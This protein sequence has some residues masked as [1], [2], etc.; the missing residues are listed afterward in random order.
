MAAG[1]VAGLLAVAL[2]ADSAAAADP[3]EAVEPAS[4]R[5]SALH[6]TQHGGASV[7]TI[8]IPAVELDST[9]RS[10]IAAEVI[11]QGVAHWVGTASPGEEGNVVLAG[12]RTTHSRPFQDL[13]RLENGDLI[14]LTDG[15]GFESM[16]RVTDVFIV[17]PGDVWIT[18]EQGRAMVTL[19]ACHPKGSARQRIVVQADLV[20]GRI[21]L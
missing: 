5:M 21:V 4:S 12:H 20:A 3:P 17:T 6:P 10:G 19:F 13:N 11:D 9:I 18:W 16:Y 7:G 1:F 15:W 8:R 14:F 2:L